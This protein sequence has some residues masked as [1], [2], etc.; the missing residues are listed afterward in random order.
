MQAISWTEFRGLTETFK[1]GCCLGLLEKG[2]AVAGKVLSWSAFRLAV[3]TRWYSCRKHQY[4]F[5]GGNTYQSPSYFNLSLALWLLLQRHLAYLLYY[6]AWS[7]NQTPSTGPPCFMQSNNDR[8]AENKECP[9]GGMYSSSGMMSLFGASR[10]KQETF[11]GSLQ[12]WTCLMS[13][14]SI[15]GIWQS[16]W[17]KGFEYSGVGK[18]IEKLTER[19]LWFKE[20]RAAS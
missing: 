18:R 7:T 19:G 20:I 15:S 12:Y 1:H 11:S 4:L 16:K 8:R 10:E 5:K 6:W 17:V 14:Y 13:W 2:E 9:K 3:S